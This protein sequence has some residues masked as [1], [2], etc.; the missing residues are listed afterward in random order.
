V[1]TSR[2]NSVS[3]RDNSCLILMPMTENMVQTAK[4]TA[5]ATV[6]MVRTESCF[7]LCVAISEAH[8]EVS[9]HE[10]IRGEQTSQLIQVNPIGI[11][12]LE[13]SFWSILGTTFYT[14]K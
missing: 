8:V 2:P 9:W 13:Y 11:G 6:F 3:L 12:S 1:A 4:F 7:V 10:L 14:L 5:N